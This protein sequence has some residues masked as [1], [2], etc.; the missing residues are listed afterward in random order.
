MARVKKIRS[1]FDKIIVIIVGGI[2]SVVML[3]AHLSS[4]CDNFAKLPISLSSHYAPTNILTTAPFISNYYY[5][6]FTFSADVGCNSYLS[7]AQIFDLCDF[8]RV[9]PFIM[10]SLMLKKHANCSMTVRIIVFLF[11]YSWVIKTLPSV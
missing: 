8:V 7:T 10:P 4:C 11:V 5:Y 3:I 6:N 9:K 1:K 2:C